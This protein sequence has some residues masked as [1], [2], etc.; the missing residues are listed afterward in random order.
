MIPRAHPL[1]RCIC[2]HLA[3][4][5][6]HPGHSNRLFL[7][8]CEGQCVCMSYRDKGSYHRRMPLDDESWINE[9]GQALFANKL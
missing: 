8:R 9:I 5:H 1:D 4:W 2:G 6:N 7:G 3:L